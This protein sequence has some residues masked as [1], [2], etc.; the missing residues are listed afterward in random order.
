MVRKKDIKWNLPAFEDIR[1][2]PGVDAALQDCV[3]QV[4]AQTGERGYR[5]E[6]VDGKTRSRAVVL[7]T[8]FDAMLRERWDNVLLKALANVRH[9]G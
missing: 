1:R 2:L 7:T 3:D 5:G 4:L 6:V 8:D 9:D